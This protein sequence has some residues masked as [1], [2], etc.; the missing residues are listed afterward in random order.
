MALRN[1]DGKSWFPEA[2]QNLK[3][4]TRAMLSNKDMIR[5]SGANDCANRILFNT[6]DCSRLN[7]IFAGHGM[8]INLD[9]DMQVNGVFGDNSEQNN[10][11]QT[12]RDCPTDHS[13]TLRRNT[14]YELHG[15]TLTPVRTEVYRHQCTKYFKLR[16]LSLYLGFLRQTQFY[17]FAVDTSSFQSMHLATSIEF[18]LIAQR[19]V[20]FDYLSALM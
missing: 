11:K 12:V 17:F 1:E 18:V 4:V 6:V 19:K 8:L 2:E 10:R 16:V 3:V 7:T 14:V 13:I 5:L 15:T 20:S 9:E